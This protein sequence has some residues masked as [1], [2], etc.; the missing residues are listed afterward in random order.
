[1]NISVIRYEFQVLPYTELLTIIKKHLASMYAGQ[2][3]HHDYSEAFTCK[4]ETLVNIPNLLDE[5]G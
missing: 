2:P 5:G 1:M 3:W 4:R